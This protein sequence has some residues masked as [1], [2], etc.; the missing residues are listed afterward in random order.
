MRITICRKIHSIVLS[1]SIKLKGDDYH[2][3][4][5]HDKK[6]IQISTK[7]DEKQKRSALFHESVHAVLHELNIPVGK[8]EERV[9]REIEKLA[10]RILLS[11][12]FF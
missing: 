3:I 12:A 10:S 2:A 6:E 11:S 4:I 7:L 9:V 1:D 8:K 5:D